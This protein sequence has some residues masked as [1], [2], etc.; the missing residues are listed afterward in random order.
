MWGPHCKFWL[1]TMTRNLTCGLRF[2]LT[3]PR[4]M[5]TSG[6]RVASLANTEQMVQLTEMLVDF[7]LTVCR[8]FTCFK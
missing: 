2:I 4:L 5:G 7:T 1:R 6:A 3:S 8:Q